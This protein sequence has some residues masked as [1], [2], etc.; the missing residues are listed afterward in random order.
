MN[1]KNFSIYV[2]RQ[3][4]RVL[5][6]HKKYFQTYVDD[7]IIFF[8]TLETYLRH[9]I[10]IF[11]TLN[12]NNIFIKSIKAFITYFIVNFLNQKMNFFDLIIAENKLKV[13]SLLK[14]SRTLHQLK[15]YLKLIN[16]LRK[17]V[18]FYANIFKSLQTRKT[19]LFRDKLIIENV[20]KIYS[21]KIKISNLN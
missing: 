10:K 3:I 11:N 5:K 7:I 17:Y 21:D 20:K 15:I 19:K 12:V 16:Y 9:L 2:Q 18:S 14:F 13:I 1:Y 4:D 6:N 8:K